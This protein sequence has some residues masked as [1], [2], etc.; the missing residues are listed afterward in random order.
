MPATPPRGARSRRSP[1]SSA[2]CGCPAARTSGQPGT[3]VVTDLLIL[4]RR[5]PGREPGATAWEQ[6]RLISLDGAQ[7]P[8]NEYFLS[9]PDHVLGELHAV[10]GAYRADDL[11]VT[12]AG[13][14][15]P[16]LAIGLERIAAR[17]R[18][19]G[20]TWAAAT[21][22]S[23]EASRQRTHQRERRRGGRTATCRPAAMARSPGSP[24]GRPCPIRCPAAR[25]PS[26]A[27]SLG[28]AT[29]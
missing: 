16:A 29:R 5:E 27:S 25:P 2:P 19:L 14:T 22:G 12:A 9:H 8:V 11:V 17:A 15:G 28:S 3:K 20:L 6:T 24:T 18:S 7:V 4:R 10:N 23:Q 13:D 21:T 1:T 26:C